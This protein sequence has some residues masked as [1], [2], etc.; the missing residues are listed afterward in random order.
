MEVE[1]KKESWNSRFGVILAVAG[2]AVGLGNFLRFP[3]QAAEFGGGA[4]MLA[5]FISFLILGLPACWVEWTLGRHGGSKGFNSCP[6]IFSVLLKSPRAK[7][8]G[9]FGI[10]MPVI[11]YMY[12]VNIEAWCLG[13]SLHFLKGTLNFATAAEAGAFWQKFVGIGADGAGFSLS[14]DHIGLFLLISFVLNFSLISRG[15]SKGIELF[16]TYAMPTLLLLAVIILVRVL[17][18]GVPNPE[19]PERSVSNGLG[20]MW[21]PSKF[22]IQEQQADGQWLTISHSDIVGKEFIEAKKAELEGNPT[23]RLVEQGILSQLKRPS[24]WLRAAGQIFFSLSVG[25]GTILTYASYLKSNDDIVL[26]GLSAAAANEFCEVGLGGLMTLPA[27]VAFMGVSGVAGMGT[28]GLGFNALPMVFS[29]MAYGHVFGALFFFLLF[30]AAI[31]SSLSLL[32]PGIA[33]MEEAFFINRRQSVA[34]LGFITGIGA[35]FVCY[36]SGDLKALDTMDFWAGTFMIYVF[37]MMEIICFGWFFGVEKG[38][39]EAQKGSSIRLPKIFGFI[40]KY[41]SP[42]FL[43]SIFSCWLLTDVLGVVGEHGYSSYVRELFI[44][45]N[46]V[47]VFSV[48]MMLLVMG[49]IFITINGSYLFQRIGKEE[50]KHR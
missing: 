21:N 20:F 38:I 36:F 10:A 43:L 37:S 32:Q 24:L 48:V 14:I 25:Y 50:Q 22:V 30:L 23:L 41:I 1:Q 26:S 18:L 19:M 13:Y 45:P 8:L 47:A 40:I 39:E 3:S 17:T 27:A 46:K 49:F 34:I 31:T 4:F 12:Y 11:I 15:V 33:F 28:F 2:S 7:Y 16:C 44:E 6:A 29:N 42:T 9:M 5:Y 35:L